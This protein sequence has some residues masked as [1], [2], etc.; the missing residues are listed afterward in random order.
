MVPFTEMR[1][2]EK[3]WLEEIKSFALAMSSWWWLV[4]IPRGNAVG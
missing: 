2:G 4:D 1:F 3:V